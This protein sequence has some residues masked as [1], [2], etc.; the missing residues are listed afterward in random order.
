MD[1]A[2]KRVVGNWFI[3][4]Y[5]IHTHD[6]AFVLRPALLVVWRLRNKYILVVPSTREGFSTSISCHSTYWLWLV[7]CDTRHEKRY[8][9]IFLLPP[10]RALYYSTPRRLYSTSSFLPLKYL[11]PYEELRL[12]DRRRVTESLPSHV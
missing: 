12:A 5:R 2:I 10:V 8:C 9:A 1:C 6:L 4:S 7:E 11:F 3:V